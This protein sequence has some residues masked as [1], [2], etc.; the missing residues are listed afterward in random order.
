MR[1]HRVLDDSKAAPSKN[2]DTD[3][4]G[5]FHNAAAPAKASPQ[6]DMMME[7]SAAEPSAMQP[8]AANPAEPPPMIP[9]RSG[10]SPCSKD[11][12]KI[13]T[14]FDDLYGLAVTTSDVY[15]GAT[16]GVVRSDHDG[17]DMVQVVDQQA[18]RI[19]A[20]DDH[21]FWSTNS[22]DLNVQGHDNVSSVLLPSHGAIDGVSQDAD[23]VYAISDGYL[24]SVSKATHEVTELVEGTA[25]RPLHW[26]G[27]A[28]DDEYVYFIS[29]EETGDSVDLERVRKTDGSK[30]ERL[31]SNVTQIMVPVQLMVDATSVYIGGYG[32]ITRVP[33]AGGDPVTIATLSASFGLDAVIAQ[34]DVCVF[35]A[36]DDK[37]MCVSKTDGTLSTVLSV[38]EGNVARLATHGSDLYF[39]VYVSGPAFDKQSWVG[40]L[41]CD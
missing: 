24:V 17:N 13:L 15:V 39:G 10:P 22:L 2:G 37:V 5:Q 31:A 34:D 3:D 29:Y 27:T 38:D 14:G 30:R 4:G 41:S 26:S 19:L 32:L 33:V 11:T 8:F 12:T 35:Y 40:R 6:R 18:A 1:E 36:D 9:S 7:P 16:D 28:V 25:E 21:L 23:A 20:D